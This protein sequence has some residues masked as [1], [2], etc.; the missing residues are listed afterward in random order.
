MNAIRHLSWPGKKKPTCWHCYRW[1]G[2][3]AT[4]ATVCGMGYGDCVY[5]PVPWRSL[6]RRAGYGMRWRYKHKGERMSDLQAENR[7]LREAL[8]RIK[9]QTP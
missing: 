8:E 5:K 7:R 4:G 6:L 1:T 9:E 2:G 3:M